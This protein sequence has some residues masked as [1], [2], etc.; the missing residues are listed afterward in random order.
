MDAVPWHNV[1]DFTFNIYDKESDLTVLCN[2]KQIHISLSPECFNES[3]SIQKTYLHFLEAM[4]D[5]ESDD[6]VVEEHFY[7][8][9]VRPFFPILSQIDPPPKDHQLTLNDFLLPDTVDYTVRVEHDKLVPILY[10]QGEARRRGNG[11]RTSLSPDILATFPSYHPRQI[12]LW[13]RDG[14]VGLSILATKVTIDGETPYFFKAYGPEDYASAPR[15][16]ANYKAIEDAGLDTD[17]RISR[18]HGIVRDEDS[19]KV[20]GVLLT[21]IDCGGMTLQYAIK[22]DTDLG[23]REQWA[24][25][26]TDT[27]LCLH[28]RSVL[29]ADVK[30]DNVLIDRRNNAWLIDFGGGYTEG[31]VDKDVAGTLEGDLQGL[32]RILQFLGID[33][34][35]YVA[36]SATLQQLQVHQPHEPQLYATAA[37]A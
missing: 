8:W 16:I 27:L 17:L 22:P 4:E 19:G 12:Q 13:P 23:L 15:E 33:P 36:P 7:D 1:I 9:V 35:D 31:W 30:P 29:W 26:V 10:N 14:Q 24:R 2:S 34:R 28:E 25:Q 20:F 32:V 3:P 11:A 18:L 6:F 5:E 21:F 37:S